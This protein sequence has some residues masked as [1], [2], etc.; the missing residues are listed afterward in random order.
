[1]KRS[2]DAVEAAQDR[3]P[4]RL[5][6]SKRRPLLARLDTSRSGTERAVA[7]APIGC[8]CYVKPD[9]SPCPTCSS[10]SR[11][12]GRSVE[13]GRGFEAVSSLNQEN[14]GPVATPID[15][16]PPSRPTDRLE[17]TSAN[18]SA[19]GSTNAADHRTSL[20]YQDTLP[21]E[22]IQPSELNTMGIAMILP[23]LYLGPNITSRRVVRYL[24]DVG[25]KRVLNCAAEVDS[26]QV[27]VEDETLANPPPDAV[28][29]SCSL[30]DE[31][32]KCY[33]I[34]MVD[35][36]EATGLTDHLTQA[37]QLLVETEKDSIPVY[38]H[39]Q[40]G[41]SRSVAVVLAYLIQS[42]GW[43]LQ[44]SYEYVRRRKADICPNIGFVSCL[45]EWEAA[46]R[47]ERGST[48][49]LEDQAEATSVPPGGTCFAA[50][51]VVV[52]AV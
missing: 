40:A 20:P 37:C 51:S 14:S 8:Y 4:S 28:G 27:V 7:S 22:E 41:K 13:R 36:I 29:T 43:S 47:G 30:L 21:V 5:S 23:G 24:Q 26:T 34:A 46:N 19:P 31:F 18:S 49:S 42:R 6:I 44:E 1:M 11:D 17:V 38:V 16:L 2:A 3:S 12:R 9:D 15:R 50:S 52:A 48:P 32:E 39:C 25:V 35:Q 10:S 33:K 45:M